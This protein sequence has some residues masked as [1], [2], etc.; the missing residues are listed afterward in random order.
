MSTGGAPV[1]PAPLGEVVQGV[2]LGAEP[3]GE[4]LVAGLAR[5]EVEHAPVAA[6]D[7]VGGEE[8][9]HL[10][11]EAAVDELQPEAEG[12]VGRRRMP[13]AGSVSSER[14]G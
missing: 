7:P 14:S 1:D 3:L 8:R 10:L 12:P 9:L 11:G 6:G 2:G 4:P 13:R 5:E